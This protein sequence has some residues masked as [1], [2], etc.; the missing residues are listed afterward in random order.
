MCNCLPMSLSHHLPTSQVVLLLLLPLL[1]LAGPTKTKKNLAVGAKCG[2]T[3]P[4]NDSICEEGTRSD[5]L[6]LLKLVS[7][8]NN[9]HTGLPEA[10][11]QAPPL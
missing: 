9:R 10:A 1:A 2:H 7:F 6:T 11:L 8:I 4:W 3:G 5:V